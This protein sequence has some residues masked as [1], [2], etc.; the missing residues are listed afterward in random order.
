MPYIL[1]WLFFQWFEQFLYCVGTFCSLEMVKYYCVNTSIYS[2]NL[3]LDMIKVILDRLGLVHCIQM[4]DGKFVLAWWIFIRDFVEFVLCFP[5]SVRNSDW[6]WV[7]PCLVYSMQIW[8]LCSV[9]SKYIVQLIR[10][11]GI[12]DY[13]V[14]IRLDGAELFIH[15]RFLK[16]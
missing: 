9:D 4:V 2:V 6:F 13:T 14:Y 12:T 15:Y 10:S 1:F 11:P 8:N 5:C 3:G 7:R 16:L